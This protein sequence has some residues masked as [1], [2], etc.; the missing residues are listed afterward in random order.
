[1]LAACRRKKR[2]MC[3][4][5]SLQGAEEVQSAATTAIRSQGTVQYQHRGKARYSSLSLQSME[6]V[7]FNGK[8]EG[9][10]F[11]PRR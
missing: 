3:T 9:R 1:M 4:S 11:Q 8:A 5:L 6:N 10:P 2:S 7:Q